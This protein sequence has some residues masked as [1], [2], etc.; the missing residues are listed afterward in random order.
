MK[1]HYFPHRHKAELVVDVMTQTVT[2]VVEEVIMMEEW[3]SARQ[4][5][6]SHYQFHRIVC[7]Q[8]WHWSI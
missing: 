3:Q 7:L 8:M 6:L 5:L 1:F 2:V 4:Y